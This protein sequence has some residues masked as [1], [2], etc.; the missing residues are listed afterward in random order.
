MSLPKDVD[1]ALVS[2]ARLAWNELSLLLDGEEPVTY[3][4]DDE[5]FPFYKDLILTLFEV[6]EEN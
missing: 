2:S 1:P 4:T 5:F 6:H 3:S